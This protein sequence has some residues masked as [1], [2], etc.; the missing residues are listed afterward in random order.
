MLVILNGVETVHKKWFAG[1]LVAALNTFEV[2]GYTVDFNKQPFEIFDSSGTLVYGSGVNSLLLNQED[3]SRNDAGHAVLDKVIQLEDE[4]FLSGSRENHYSVMY[5]DLDYDFGI[6]TTLNF[7][8]YSLLNNPNVIERYNARTVENFVISGTFSRGFIEQMITQLG[9]ENVKIINI[10]RNPSVARLMH[11]KPPEYYIKN[12][13]YTEEHD[14]Q[15]LHKSIITSAFLV[16]FEDVV[17]V[18]FE[19]ILRDG[20]FTF[21]GKQIMLPSTHLPYNNWITQFE[22][23]EVVALRNEHIDSC[24]EELD[25]FN[26]M[27]LDVEKASGDAHYKDC[28]I[29]AMMGYEPLEFSNITLPNAS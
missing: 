28:N 17:T 27:F 3:G 10:V 7:P 23:S 2:D 16:Q 19:D 18:K 11:E 6:T 25:A 14:T 15:K 22:A 20:Y 29:F 24:L 12:S 13:T 9:R 4:H 1:R 26:E 5:V 8:P 21:D